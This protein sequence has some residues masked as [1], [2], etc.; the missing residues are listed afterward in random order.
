MATRTRRKVTEDLELDAI[1]TPVLCPP[2]LSNYPH[3]V[4]DVKTNGTRG[5]GTDNGGSTDFRAHNN[6][7]HSR[8]DGSSGRQNSLTAVSASSSLSYVVVSSSYLTAVVVAAASD[9]PTL[10]YGMTDFAAK[11][12]TECNNAFRNMCTMGLTLDGNNNNNSN[13]NNNKNNNNG[14]ARGGDNANDEGGKVRREEGEKELITLD[15][16]PAR[17]RK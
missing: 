5:G 9:T 13:N 4:G 14:K 6:G 7:N 10:F 12:L 15:C 11:M 3:G 17:T 2:H 16:P 8:R 1:G